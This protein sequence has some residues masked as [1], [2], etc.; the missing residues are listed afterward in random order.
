MKKLKIVFLILVIWI[1]VY[2]LKFG[3]KP[4]TE[5]LKLKVGLPSHDKE[6]SL[7]VE[8]N[9]IKKQLEVDIPSQEKPI[10]YSITNLG[11]KTIKPQVVVNGLDWFTGRSIVD[12]ALNQLDLKSASNEKVVITLFDFVVNN[13]YHWS[14]PLYETSY[15][16]LENPVQYFNSWGYGFCS[17]SSS[18]L[19][20]LLS[21]A[22][23]EGRMVNI[24]DNVVAEVFYDGSWHALD[25]DLEVYYRNFKGEIASVEEIVDNDQLLNSPIWIKEVNEATKKIIRE[26]HALAFSKPTQRNTPVE[27]FMASQ[28]YQ[29]ELIYRLSPDEEIRFY[30]NFKGKYYWAYRDL[31]PPEFTNGVLISKNK[32]G[33]FRLELPF[34]ILTTYIYR[35]NLCQAI[36]KTRFSLDGLRWKKLTNCRDDTINLADL[37]PI[38][39]GSYPTEKYFLVL[40]FS[41]TD[42]QILTQFQAAPK[43]IPHLNSG[44]NDVELKEALDSNVKLE[45]GYTRVY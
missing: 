24:V 2:P 16:Y 12:Y 10:Y 13:R 4:L 18:V 14:P 42:Y 36:I 3:S 32:G 29:N 31:Q 37:F 43:S 19:I 7:I 28:D 9:Q 23:F 21:L 17:N 45:F 1:L 35:P 33:Y 8:K 25:P 34:P 40:P 30:Y 41:I 27:G 26:V 39:E 11:Q 22:G 6:I 5:E 38:G 15:Y 20:Q 44:I